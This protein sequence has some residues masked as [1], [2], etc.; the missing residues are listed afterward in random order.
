MLNNNL[1]EVTMRAPD[2]HARYSL[3][4]LKQRAAKLVPTLRERA[5]D[6]TRARRIPDETIRDL[7]DADLFYLLKPRKYGGP[8]V[9]PDIAFQVADELGRGDGSASWIWSVMT[10]HDLFASLYPQQFQE[11]YWGKDRT[12]SASSFS[13]G[14]LAKPAPGGFR[15]SG[16]WSFCSGVDNAAWLFLGAIFGPPSGGSP[17]PDIRYVWVPKGDFGVIDDW[18]VMGLR[19]TGSKSVTLDNAFIPEHRVVSHVAMA[20]GM[21]PGSKVH[22][23]WLYRAPMWTF[24]PFTISAPAHGIAQGGLEAFIDE[25]KVR[26]TSFDHSPLAKKPGM[27][28]RVAEASAMIDAGSLLYKRSFRETMEKLEAGETLS[29]EHRARNRRDQGYSVLLAKQG[30]ETLVGGIGGRGIF[31]SNRVQR[32]YRDLIAMSGHIVANWDAPAYSYGQIMLGGPPS[33]IFV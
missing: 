14:G 1:G 32:A 6:T 30:A 9:R 2:D 24:V 21:A 15:L 13:P 19:G 33:E 18:D 17:M 11:E 12:L 4:Q 8:A 29:L 10:I 7:W 22:D 20:E 27:Q 25:M 3:D 16:K 5:S 23:H 26:E 28:L 31:E